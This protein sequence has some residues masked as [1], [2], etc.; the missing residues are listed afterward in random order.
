MFQITENIFMKKQLLVVAGLLIFLS[1]CL[2]FSQKVNKKIP[3]P[4]KNSNDGVVV[5]NNT[6]YPI[7]EYSKRLTY[8][9]FGKSLNGS[10]KPN[11]CGN[12]FAGFHT[13][14]D[15]ETTPGET[16]VDVPIYAIF[17]GMVK[18]KTVVNGYGGLLVLEHNFGDEIYTSYY[19]HID[20][21]KSL[22]NQDT[23][24]KAGQKIGSLAKECS[25]ESGGE[26][27]HLHFAI[28]KGDAVDVRGYVPFQANLEEWI[29][30]QELLISQ[31]AVESDKQ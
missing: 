30:P 21:N 20:L 2:Y 16:D 8:R 28:H 17:D 24:V 3:I 4:V 27:K 1:G 29:N 19:G 11:P 18:Q 13:G 26:R 22:I 31:G 15:L 14:D 6:F 5:S 7:K 9:E 25:N 23:A 10:E 12:P